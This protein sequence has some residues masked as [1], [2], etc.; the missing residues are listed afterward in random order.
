LT[1]PRDHSEYTVRTKLSHWLTNQR[2]RS[3]SLRQDKKEL[4]EGINYK[5]AHSDRVRDGRAW[6]IRY[7]Q[8]KQ[9]REENKD[10]QIASENKPLAN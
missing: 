8:L 1:I 6:E 7:Q 3:E 4:L 5:T 9:L 2:K 10:S